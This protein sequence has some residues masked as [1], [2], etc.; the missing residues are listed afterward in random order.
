MPHPHERILYRIGN[1][2]RVNITFSVAN[3]N[4][5]SVSVARGACQIFIE[6]KI[7][8]SGKLPR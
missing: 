8:S 7:R 2:G 5:A 3:A 1:R 6:S 4:N